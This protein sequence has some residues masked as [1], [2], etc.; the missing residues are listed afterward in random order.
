MTETN[1]GEHASCQIGT[2]KQAT[3]EH[4]TLAPTPNIEA[5]NKHIHITLQAQPLP[6][7]PANINLLVPYQMNKLHHLWPMTL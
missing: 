4:D 2:G 6:E 3:D 5:A 7:K 1:N